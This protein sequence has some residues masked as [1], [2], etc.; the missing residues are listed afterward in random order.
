MFQNSMLSLINQLQ[1]RNF[2]LKTKIVVLTAVMS[3]TVL[4]GLCFW[5]L[6]TMPKPDLGSPAAASSRLLQYFQTCTVEVEFEGSAA[7]HAVFGKSQDALSD[8]ALD[9]V[10]ASVRRKFEEIHCSRHGK[11]Y[12]YETNPLNVS[13][14]FY[15]RP[16]P[17]DPQKIKI[18]TSIDRASL[19][20]VLMW[21]KETNDKPLEGGNIRPQDMLKRFDS[22]LMVVDKTPHFSGVKNE[23]ELN[24]ELNFYATEITQSMRPHADEA[25]KSE[26]N[27]LSEIRGR[28]PN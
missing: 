7:G 1:I 24:E 9:I 3:A 22:Q 4:S 27:L 12:T 26:A 11:P 2:S 16:D 13:I 17:S 5:I 20:H 14:I 28:A 19:F 6:L 8:Q 18:N 21:K 15:L 25:A 23:S 10:A